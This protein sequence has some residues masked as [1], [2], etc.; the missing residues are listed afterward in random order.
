MKGFAVAPGAL[1]TDRAKAAWSAL[2]KYHPYRYAAYRPWAAE[3]LKFF[4][5]LNQGR[6]VATA[7]S[8]ETDGLLLVADDKD[9]EDPWGKLCNKLQKRVVSELDNPNLTLTSPYLFM[10]TMGLGMI[11]DSGEPR[12]DFNQRFFSSFVSDEIKMYSHWGCHTGNRAVFDFN[13]ELT[14]LFTLSDLGES[15][16]DRI[17]MPAESVYL[18][19][20]V[21]SD[22]PITGH[23][24]ACQ[25]GLIEMVESAGFTDIKEGVRTMLKGRL[26]EFAERP[27]WDSQYFFEG[28]YVSKNRFDP[29]GS[30]EVILI[31]RQLESQ[32]LTPP[33][34]F[35]E[36]A[37]ESLAF[38]LPCFTPG[39]TIQESLTKERDRI[40]S[41][42]AAAMRHNYAEKV[43]VNPAMAKLL[44]PFEDW[45][46]HHQRVESQTRADILKALTLVLNAVLYIT[47]YPEDLE[48]EYPT[49]TPPLLQ[50]L[51]A[52]AE[53][54]DLPPDKLARS[55]K[56]INDLGYR[57]VKFCGRKIAKKV[58]KLRSNNSEDG[59][60]RTFMGRQGT[61]R[62]L[63]SSKGHFKQDQ[64]IWIMPIPDPTGNKPLTIYV[65]E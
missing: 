53:S 40:S 50:D 46:E 7:L 30:L 64:H 38:Y 55:R 13:E 27:G 45:A 24:T 36:V 21:Q 49:D 2:K 6:L 8:L 16:L 23:L 11:R 61:W 1:T 5:G 37:E 18:H 15:V 32:I 65:V 12:S 63:D 26:P 19:F 39:I 58:E 60:Q 4:R 28:A 54:S 9:P 52:K 29:E 34:S 47:S 22:I 25:R 43:Q 62:F 56:E 42:H 48:E 33:Q 3:M 20:G 44:G 17:Q 14:K 35:L 31:A 51:I 10:S 57:K 59:R 41:A